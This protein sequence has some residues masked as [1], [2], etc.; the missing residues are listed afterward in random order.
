TPAIAALSV[1]LT[2]R[3][4]RGAEGSGIPQVIASLHAQPSAFGSRRLT[5]RILFGTVLISMRAIAGGF[6]NGREAPTVQIGASLMF[7]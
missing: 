2:R 7:N 6:T 4:I 1:W 3:F 5:L